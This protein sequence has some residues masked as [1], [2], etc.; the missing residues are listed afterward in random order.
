MKHVKNYIGV[1]LPFYFILLSLFISCSENKDPLSSVS[2][3]KSFTF[4]PQFNPDLENVSTVTITGSDITIPLPYG[5]SLDGLIASFT[6]SGASVEIGNVKQVSGVTKN[7]FSN[8]LIYSVIAENGTKTDYTVTVMKDSPRIPR[9]YVNTTGGVEIEEKDKEKYVGST[10]RIEDID[11]YYTDGT[12]FTSAAEMKG[13]GNSTW[14][15]VPKK[16]YRIKLESKNSLLGMSNDKDWAL[17]ANYYDKTLLRNITAFEISRIAEMNWTPA[18]VSVDF[19]MNGTYRG[20]YTLTEHVKVS[21][22]RLDMELV[23]PSDNSG[24]ALTGGYLLE[25]DFHF[26]EPYKFRTDR[27]YP[28][29]GLPIMFKDPDEPT[30][31]QFEYVKEYFN[32]AEQVLYSTNFKDPVNGY[33]KYIDVESFINY[34]IVQELAKN[35]DGNMRGSCYMAIR[36]NGKIEMPLV[37]DFDLA[38]GNADYITWEQGAS[39]REWD[40]WYIKTCSPWFDR[41]F[42][43]PYFVSELKKRWNELKPQLDEIPGFIREHASVLEEPQA[44]NFRPISSGGAGWSITKPEWNTSII[45]GSY[46]AE[47]NYLVD[48]VEKRLQWLDTNI[49]GL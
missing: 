13:R 31:A 15:G 37:W 8:P 25:L 35:V 30:V 27:G 4:Q 42:E 28:D 16:P 14:W 44:R 33:R 19:Y 12:Q 32:T 22:E 46:A 1:R 7:D 34:Y 6:Y 29:E 5:T 41:F 20:V 47:V 3:L 24:E 26:D 10:I 21:K 45:R 39:S 17:L 38:F 36:R 23:Q 40:G 11:R 9:V 43:D 48:F 49:N 2:E 18:S